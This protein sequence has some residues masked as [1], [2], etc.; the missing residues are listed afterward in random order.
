VCKNETRLSTHEAV[1]LG[2]TPGRGS[3]ALSDVF[4]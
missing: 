4:C 3:M 2:W 1:G